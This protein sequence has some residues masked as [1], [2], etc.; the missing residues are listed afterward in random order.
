MMMMKVKV[1]ELVLVLSWVLCVSAEVQHENIYISG[2]SDSDGEQ[3][4]GLDGEELWYADFVNKRGVYPLPSFSNSFRYEEGV[5]E[6]AVADEHTCKLNLNLALRGMKDYPMENDPP[7]SPIIY[8]RDDVELDQQNTLICHVT[9]FYPAP[10]K[11]HWTKNGQNV[12][13]GTSI[14][15]PFP[16]KDG[17]FRQTSRLEFTPQL[18]DVYSCTVDHPA[19]DQPLTRIWDV[20]LMLTSLCVFCLQMWRSSSPVLDLQCSVDWV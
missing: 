13:E 11:I 7:S 12:T 5:Y 20:E 2:C 17:S 9:G 8:S 3:M 6:A 19:L 18:G 10:V 15:V 4:Y 1:S 14:D 16:N